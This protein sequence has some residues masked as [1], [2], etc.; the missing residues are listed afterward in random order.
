M[1]RRSARLSAL[2]ASFAHTRTLN[3]FSIYV[4]D[5]NGD[6]RSFERVRELLA[7][8]A[9]EIPLLAVKVISS[10]PWIYP[11]WTVDPTPA[12]DKISELDAASWEE[13]LAWLQSHADDDI[14]PRSRPWRLVVASDVSA[15]PGVH[16]E[17]TVVITQ[18]SHAI[19]DGMAWS[20]VAAGL[21]GHGPTGMGPDATVDRVCK[22]DFVRELAGIP[23]DIARA[24]RPLIRLAK[25]SA[26]RIHDSENAITHPQAE[27]DRWIRVLPLSKDAFKVP[28]E[29]VTTS[30][31]WRAA[32][33]ID[34]YRRRFD[35][36]VSELSFEVPLSIRREGETNVLNALVLREVDAA[37]EEDDKKKLELIGAAMS[38]ARR[39]ARGPEAR[40]AAQVA[41]L[42]PARLVQRDVPPKAAPVSVSSY[43]R[44][45]P[46]ELLGA[47]CV[48]S[49]GGVGR[50]N[51][52]LSVRAVGYGD[53]V[54]MS[55]SGNSY[56]IE[57]PDLLVDLMMG[58]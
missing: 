48:W 41:D 55:V 54:A 14:D 9:S 25:T 17:C 40:L 45:G 19:A 36:D 44:R 20:E 30:V 22:L 42:L 56:A 2:D 43:V 12:Q 6:S 29:T 4:F 34:C 49:G 1:P 58:A 57:H 28:G 15:V 8:R 7:R 39:F 35:L 38:E 31:I 46:L 26:G 37:L 16:G 27:F 50:D 21:F 10:S 52:S 5:G 18:H 24:C 11:R 47:P 13:V 51:A 23:V 32:V 33:G 3:P 53:T